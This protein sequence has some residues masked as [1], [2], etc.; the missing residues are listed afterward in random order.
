[1][2]ISKIIILN[3]PK[4]I[5]NIGVCNTK[6]SH[7]WLSKK[8]FNYAAFFMVYNLKRYLVKTLV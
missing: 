7:C 5:T 8:L 1:M 6:F 2:R 3:K 4:S